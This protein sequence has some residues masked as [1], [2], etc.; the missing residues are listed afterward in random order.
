MKRKRLFLLKIGAFLVCLTTIW[1]VA[2]AYMGKPLEF[3]KADGATLPDDK[4]GILDYAWVARFAKVEIDGTDGSYE[5]SYAGDYYGY[6]RLKPGEHTIQWSHYFHKRG[7]WHEKLILKVEA[8]HRYRLK[9]EDCYWCTEFRATGWIV[10]E[11][12]GEVVSGS[13]PDWPSW[14]L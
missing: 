6:S 11:G 2:C 1:L 5:L 14:M 12:T 10:D 4:V 3:P 9:T 7:W 13:L 8:G